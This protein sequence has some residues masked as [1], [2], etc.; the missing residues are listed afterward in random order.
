MVVR[1]QQATSEQ[2]VVTCTGHKREKVQALP[3][4]PSPPSVIGFA[5]AV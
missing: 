3:M 5:P 1:N 4:P 2:L